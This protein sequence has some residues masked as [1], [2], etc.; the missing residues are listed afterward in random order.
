MIP[1]YFKDYFLTSDPTAQEEIVW[2]SLNLSTSG[3]KLEDKNDK[4][5]ISSL[6]L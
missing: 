1:D 6:S 5:A 3:S 2:L 4:Q